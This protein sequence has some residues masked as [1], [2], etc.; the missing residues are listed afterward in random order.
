MS[1]YIKAELALNH[2]VIYTDESGRYFR[3]SAGTWSWRN[4]NPGNLVP[5]KVSGRHNQIGSTGKFAI[6]PD[7]ENGHLALIDC[8][9]TTYKNSS[10]DDLVKFYAP[11]KDGNNI[12]K[13]KKFLHDETGV[14]DN[15]KVKD[16]TSIE[17]DKLWCAIEKIEGYKEGTITEVFPVIQVY[18]NKHE[19]TDY[20]IKTMGWNAKQ[21]CLKMAK[22]E[23]LDLVICSHLGNDYL[24]ARSGS[25]INGSLGNLVVKDKVVGK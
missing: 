20:N 17:F 1:N 15:K 10:I 25:S 24:R 23:M 5:G 19:I 13:Y 7:Y 8:L 22:Q 4:N 3:F 6:F 14:N 16:F 12:K 21:E 18:K 11:E 2:T 9:Q